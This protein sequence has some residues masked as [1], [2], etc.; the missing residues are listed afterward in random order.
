MILLVSLEI[1]IL[2]KTCETHL[3]GGV[4]L[5]KKKEDEKWVQIVGDERLWKNRHPKWK[6][7]KN[8]W[9]RL[10]HNWK[11]IS[12]RNETEKNISSLKIKMR[13]LDLKSD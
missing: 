12:V 4:V 13:D 2:T 11:L 3:F 7:N 9:Y 8:D 10:F 1:K 6:W 5:M